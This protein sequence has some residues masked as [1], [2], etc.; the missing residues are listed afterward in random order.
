MVS[1]V[2]VTSRIDDAFVLP[3][4]SEF[5]KRITKKTMAILLCSPNNPTGHVYTRQELMDLLEL[6]RRHDI[7]LVVDEVYREFCYDGGEFASVLSFP[8]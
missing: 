3:S 4:I 7:F 8:E 5:E 6:C 2:P 1:L